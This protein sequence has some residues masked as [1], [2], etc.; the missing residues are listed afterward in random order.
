M[1]GAG[2]LVKRLVERTLLHAQAASRAQRRRGRARLLLHQEVLA[3]VRERPCE[4]TRVARALEHGVRERK[5]LVY[6]A[7]HAEEVRKVQAHLAPHGV[8]AHRLLQGVRRNVVVA[9]VHGRKRKVAV[10]PVHGLAYVTQLA[11]VLLHAAVRQ[12]LED[13][14]EA[15][16]LH[17]V[18]RGAVAVHVLLRVLRDAQEHGERLVVLSLYHQGLRVSQ[19]LRHST[20]VHVPPAAAPPSCPA[21]GGIAYVF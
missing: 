18:R 3:E 9:G 2:R 8:P 12:P 17:L 14:G 10:Q 7:V 19:A 15:E 20:F 16:P 21:R 5:V 6:V 4:V 1:R 13:R 11:R